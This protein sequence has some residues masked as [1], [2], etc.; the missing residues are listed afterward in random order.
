MGPPTPIPI[1]LLRIKSEKEAVTI[2]NKE[3]TGKY[4]VLRPVALS[5]PTFQLQRASNKGQLLQLRGKVV[6]QQSH[7]KRFRTNIVIDPS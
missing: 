1:E 6:R 7:D 5:G 2:R 3:Y 4:I